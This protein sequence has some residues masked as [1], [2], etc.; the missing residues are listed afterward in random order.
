MRLS[1][2]GLPG[3]QETQ[4]STPSITKRRK[5]GMRARVGGLHSWRLGAEA[6]AGDLDWEWFV[7]HYL[8]MGQVDFAMKRSCCLGDS[9]DS[10]QGVY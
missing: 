6:K 9:F 3:L 10:S 5:R 1:G 4:G 8:Q 2:R 7:R